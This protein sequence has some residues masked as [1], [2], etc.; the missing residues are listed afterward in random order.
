LEKLDELLQSKESKEEF[1][2]EGEKAPPTLPRKNVVYEENEAVSPWLFV[3]EGIL[4][5]LTKGEK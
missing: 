2:N 1:G 4:V 5:Y 3:W